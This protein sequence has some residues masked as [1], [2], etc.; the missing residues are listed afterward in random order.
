MGE[1]EEA[2]LCVFPL[3]SAV[4]ATSGRFGR[5]GGQYGNHRLFPALSKLPPLFG[6]GVLAD[7]LRL[8]RLFDHIALRSQLAC[9]RLRHNSCA[10]L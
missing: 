2:S 10:R 5:C 3:A 8:A 4:L 1:G 6:I 7:Q 9:H